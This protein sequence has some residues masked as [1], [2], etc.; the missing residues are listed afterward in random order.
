M[1]HFQIWHKN[2]TYFRYLEASAQIS[3]SQREMYNF[4]ALKCFNAGSIFCSCK[5]IAKGEINVIYLYTEAT[6]AHYVLL[7]IVF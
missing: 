3:V 6:N 5:Y 4:W 7:F 2:H 1:L